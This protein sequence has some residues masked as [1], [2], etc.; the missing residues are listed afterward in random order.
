MRNVSFRMG[1]QTCVSI[2]S[3]EYNLLS[4]ASANIMLLC[5]VTKSN[6]SPYVFSDIQ[7]KNRQGYIVLKIIYLNWRTKGVPI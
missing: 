3:E 5:T 4:K 1:Y 6:C 2:S 7:L